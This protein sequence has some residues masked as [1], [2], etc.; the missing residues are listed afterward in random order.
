MSG[1]W[2]LIVPTWVL[3]VTA[4]IANGLTLWLVISSNKANQ[5]EFRAYIVGAAL[6]GV[7]KGPK[8]PREQYRP[9]PSDYTGPWRLYI[10]NFG[11]TPGVILKVEWGRCAKSEF[12]TQTSVSKIIDKNI[13]PDRMQQTVL[14]MN[15]ICL[16][17]AEP[18]QY[19]HIELTERVVGE[20]IFGRITYKDIFRKEHHST[21]ALLMQPE[22]TDTITMSFAD[23]WT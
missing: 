16:P 5:R 17:S 15:E 3:A 23:D 7:P 18:Q 4:L 19:R 2:G 12:P 10:H 6:F 20:V 11:K 14:G 21:F 1:D 9:K 8:G 22:Y 13:L